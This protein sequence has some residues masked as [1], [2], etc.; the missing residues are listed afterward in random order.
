MTDLTNIIVSVG[1]EKIKLIE[2]NCT[3]EKRVKDRTKD[4]EKINSDSQEC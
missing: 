2:L 1:I 4:L 3:L